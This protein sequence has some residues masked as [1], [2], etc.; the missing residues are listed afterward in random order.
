MVNPVFKLGIQFD[1]TITLKRALVEA[2]IKEGREVRFLKN[3][4]KRVRAKCGDGCE[5]FMHQK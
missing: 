2:T 1:S 4:L 5:F 3:D